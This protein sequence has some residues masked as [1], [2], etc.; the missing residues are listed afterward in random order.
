M[1][2]LIR[3]RNMKKKTAKAC[4]T[5]MTS[6]PCPDEVPD[7]SPFGNL[8]DNHSVDRF[9]DKDAESVQEGVPDGSPFYNL[10]DDHSMDGFSDE[11]AESVQE[12]VT[13]QVNNLEDDHSV[14]GFLDEDAESVQ[15][16]EGPPYAVVGQDEISQKEEQEEK[17]V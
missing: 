11:D 1:S 15:D 2:M 6:V 17:I 9:S 7:G 14:D 3:Q 12:G 4:R 16:D 13:L 5:Q 8:K 10:E